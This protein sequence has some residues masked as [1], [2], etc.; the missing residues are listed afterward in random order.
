M[1]LKYYL[2]QNNIANNPENYYGRVHPNQIL[3]MDDVIREMKKLGTGSFRI[4]HAGHIA[5]FL[6]GLSL[7]HCFSDS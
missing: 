3:E 1:T 4:G 2:L 6:P 5:D 7:R